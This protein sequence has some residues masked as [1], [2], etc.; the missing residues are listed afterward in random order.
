M[1]EEPFKYSIGILYNNGAYHL[2]SLMYLKPYKYAVAYI[3]FVL[4][5]EIR[6]LNYEHNC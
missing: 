5:T 4:L 6:E 1:L 2:C 3:P